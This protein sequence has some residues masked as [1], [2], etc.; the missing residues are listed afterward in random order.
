MFLEVFDFL[1][2]AKV[3]S[4]IVF[5]FPLRNMYWLYIYLGV[6]SWKCFFILFSHLNNG[7]AEGRIPGFS[8]FY[9]EFYPELLYHLVTLGCHFDSH[10]FVPLEAYKNFLF[11][12]VVY[13]FHQCVYVCILCY[14]YR[15]VFGRHFTW[16]Y[17]DVW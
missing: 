8:I 12:F 14:Y 1:N 7:L 11:I 15:L 17:L 10:S 6:H 4:W 5:S 16:K 2:F 3:H 9:S 13:S